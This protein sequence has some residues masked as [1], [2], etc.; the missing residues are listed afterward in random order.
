MATIREENCSLSRTSRHLAVA[1]AQKYK[2]S[3]QRHSSA[4]MLSFDTE[5]EEL[6]IATRADTMMTA[7]S[8]PSSCTIT[9]GRVCSSHIQWAN[10]QT[11]YALHKLPLLVRAA[12]P[13]ETCLKAPRRRKQLQK[14]QEQPPD[15]P[16]NDV[17]H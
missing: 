15:N 1:G 14:I 4:P 17:S 3:L 8:P 12:P 13:S 7:L 10:R 6:N 2:L 11:H 16:G 9:N 5:E